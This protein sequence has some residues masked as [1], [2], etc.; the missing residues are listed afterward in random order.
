VLFTKDLVQTTYRR[1]VSEI[2]VPESLPILERA[3]RYEPRSLGGQAPVVWDRAEGFQVY[4]AYGNM[5]LD[6]SAGVLV[7]NA[8]HSHPAIV[9]AIVGQARHGLL[10]NY[11]FPSDIRTR[12]AQRLV[13]LAPPPLQKAFLLTTGSEATENAIKLSR[14]WG[15]KSGGPRKIVV[16]TFDGAFHG[17]TLGAQMAGG[18]P[19]LKS[20]I[21]TPLPGFVQVPFPD[22]FAGGDTTFRVFEDSLRSQGVEAGEVCAVML[23]SYHGRLVRFAPLAYMKALRRWCDDHGALLVFDEV[24]ACFGRAGKWFAFEHYGVSADLVCCGKGLTSSLPLSAVLGRADIMD[25]YGPGSMSS[26]HSGNPV[27]AAAA[28]AN[29][30]VIE[31]EGLVERAVAMG[32]VLFDE[33]HCIADEH[34]DVVGAVSGKGLVAGLRIVRPVTE[35][36]DHDLAQRIVGVAVER[37]LLLLKP[38]GPAVIKIHP[39]LTITADAI[40]DGAVA[41]AEAFGIARRTYWATG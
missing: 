9:E 8:G 1:I 2:P 18:N 16:V 3:S 10:H 27:C 37:G 23:E 33:L 14:T 21:G 34:S 6:W 36:P 11:A 38:V 41:L 19:A 5:W 26:T 40:R 35:E 30:D 20:W 17:R 28:L 4:D 32:S 24:Q 39:P 12:L 31:R 25:L 29:I 22:D 15:Q 13:E 7:A